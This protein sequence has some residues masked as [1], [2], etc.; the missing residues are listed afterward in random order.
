MSAF[1]KVDS[2]SFQMAE[3][4]LEEEEDDEE[5]IVERRLQAEQ[6]QFSQQLREDPKDKALWLRFLAFQVPFVVF[7]Q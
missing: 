5:D 7:M 1:D 4:V 3:A 2:K 6:R